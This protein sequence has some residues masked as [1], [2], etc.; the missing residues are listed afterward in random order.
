M[1]MEPRRPKPGHTL[2]ESEAERLGRQIASIGEID[3]T[4]PENWDLNLSPLE[5]AERRPIF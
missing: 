2:W 3:F 1:T 5:I 4:L